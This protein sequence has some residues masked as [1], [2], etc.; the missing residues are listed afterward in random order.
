MSMQGACAGVGPQQE[1]DEESLMTVRAVGVD[2]K[3][4]S[5]LFLLEPC[6]KERLEKGAIRPLYNSTS[7]PTIRIL[8]WTKRAL[9]D[10]RLQ[11]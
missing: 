8:S 5:L 9:N 10:F 6:M 7:V 1:M 2:Y 3:K 11:L 4:R